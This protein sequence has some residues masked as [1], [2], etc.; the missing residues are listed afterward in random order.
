MIRP[1]TPKVLPVHKLA[2][3]TV[4]R[5]TS[6]PHSTLIRRV[7]FELKLW[8]RSQLERELGSIRRPRRYTNQNTPLADMGRWKTSSGKLARCCGLCAVPRKWRFIDGRQKTGG[9]I[10]PDGG[11]PLRDS[12]FRT[13]VRLGNVRRRGTD[14]RQDRSGRLRH[15]LIA[16]I[17]FAPIQIR[18]RASDRWTGDGRRPGHIDSRHVDPAVL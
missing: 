12:T 3:L 16:L 2:E 4:E 14:G 9:S 17:L 5:R 1:E 13:D 8:R 6:A 7:R 15:L 11:R 18:Y 10:R